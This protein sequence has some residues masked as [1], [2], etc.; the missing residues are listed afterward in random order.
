MVISLGRVGCCSKNSSINF[1][2]TALVETNTLIELIKNTSSHLD[3]DDLTKI[4]G[5]GFEDK[6]IYLNSYLSIVTESIF[7]K[8]PTT[9]HISEKSY[10]PFFYFQLP[11]FVASYGHVKKMKEEYGLDFFDDIIDHSYDNEFDAQKRLQMII[12]EIKRL[13]SIQEDVKKFSIT[14]KNSY[15]IQDD[16]GDTNFGPVEFF[17]NNI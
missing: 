7:D 12:E 6:E 4:A 17:E 1:I 2:K 15:Q 13:N 5:Y 3:I 11:I 16:L 8:Y 9:I 10:K 14:S